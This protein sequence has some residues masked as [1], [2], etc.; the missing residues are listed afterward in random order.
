[1]EET[2][3][4]ACQKLMIELGDKEERLD[5]LQNDISV[6]LMPLPLKGRCLYLFRDLESL[7]STF[8]GYL[9][10]DAMIFS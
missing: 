3:D 1:M 9:N 4:H 8:F 7:L 5:I 6:C 2:L 10:K